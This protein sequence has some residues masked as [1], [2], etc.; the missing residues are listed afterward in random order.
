MK[1]KKQLPELFYIQENEKTNEYCKRLGLNRG[2][3]KTEKYSYGDYLIFKNKLKIDSYYKIG[4]DLLEKHY[5]YAVFIDLADYI[6]QKQPELSGTILT[7][8]SFKINT[9]DNQEPLYYSANGGYR[10]PN[11]PRTILEIKTDGNRIPIEPKWQ[12]KTRGGYEYVIYEEFNRKIYGRIKTG[13][14]NWIPIY[15]YDK[16]NYSFVEKHSWDLLPYNP[17]LTTLEKELEEV[18]LKEKE[19]LEKIEGLKK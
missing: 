5:P 11:Y 12:E 7:S 10:L 8:D 14:S 2:D 18:R 17:L 16:G 15:W 9:S 13:V 1:T 6:E 19:I 4:L 3:Y